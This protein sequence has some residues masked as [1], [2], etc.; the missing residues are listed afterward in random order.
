[1]KKVII[2]SLLFSALALPA[3]SSLAQPLPTAGPTS[4]F[5]AIFAPTA[6]LSLTN[7]PLPPTKTPEGQPTSEWNGIPIMAGAVTGEGEQEGY[8]FTIKASPQQI[9][10]YYQLELDKLG[11][12][13]FAGGDEDSSM[14][15]FMNN[16]SETLTIS[17]IAKG[18]EALVLLVK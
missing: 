2:A 6:T 17:I 12:Q 11:W 14:L 10:E 1:M 8:V 3:C 7:T 13:P 9:Q 16:A 4:T 5:S 15:V 18:D